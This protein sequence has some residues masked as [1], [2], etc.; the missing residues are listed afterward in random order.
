MGMS[1]KL[2]INSEEVD[3]IADSKAALLN[4][5]TPFANVILCIVAAF[6]IILLIWS[7]FAKIDQLTVAT[8]KVIPS[9]QVKVIQSL[10]GGIIKEILVK[11]GNTVK[12]G[13]TLLILDDTRYKS[14]YAQ[15]YAKYLVLT[16]MI[17][18]LT[19]Q[20]N[21]QENINF[22]KEVLEN[23]PDIAKSQ[24]SLFITNKQALAASIENLKK[25][26]NLTTEEL[27]IM[28]PLVLKGI[29]PKLDYIRTQRTQNDIQGK[30]TATVD[31]YHKKA[32][33]ELNQSKAELSTV[34]E[35]LISLKDKMVRTTIVSPVNGIVKKIYITTIGGVVNPG[36]AVMDIVPAEDTLLVEAYVNP[37]DIA[38]IHPGQKA[39]VKITAYDFSVYGD[40]EGQVELVGADAVEDSKMT[41]PQANKPQAYYIVNV[42][43]DKNYLGSEKHKLPIIAGMMATV[44]IVTGE[45]TVFQYL[46]KP[47]MKAKEEALR[48]R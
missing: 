24:E 46:M 38:F 6:L 48:E 10:D 35:G 14:D 2:K 8:G 15:A 42:R 43:T 40:L 44:H 47:L 21:D 28:E 26:F 19:A 13:Q 23:A 11:E 37:K 18:R 34:V 33:E 12:A 3:Y 22:P 29:V 39:I 20:I 7:Y 4:Q 36:V 5:T 25:S 1:E 45:K 16:A 32:S 30:I 9:S 17:A 41:G 27:K 31:D